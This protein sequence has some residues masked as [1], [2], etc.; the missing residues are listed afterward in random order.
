[1]SHVHHLIELI[2]SINKTEEM[3]SLHKDHDELDLM[4]AQYEALKTKQIGQLIDELAMPPFQSIE[5]ISLIKR[6][7]N[8]YY[9][10]INE[11]IVDHKEL[12][13]L[14]LAIS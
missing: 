5:S 12:K 2:D 7:V 8:K 6:I 13:K 1:M 10:S 11:E 9:P 3:I 14:A 4:T